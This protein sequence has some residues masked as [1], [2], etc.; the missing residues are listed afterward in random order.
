MPL[1]KPIVPPSRDALRILRQLAFAGTLGGVALA[2]DRRQRI[3]TAN[4]VRENERRLKASRYYHGAGAEAVKQLQ[5]YGLTGLGAGDIH[6]GDRTIN[7]KWTTPLQDRSLLPGELDRLYLKERNFKDR[8]T[9][10]AATATTATAPIKSSEK[11]HSKIRQVPVN[12]D[13]VMPNFLNSTRVNHGPRIRHVKS[14]VTSSNPLR[15]RILQKVLW[16]HEQTQQK[17]GSGVHGIQIVQNEGQGT[18]AHQIFSVQSQLPIESETILRGV[19]QKSNRNLH[20]VSALKVL[21]SEDPD[22]GSQQRCAVKIFDLLNQSSTDQDAALEAYA[23]ARAYLEGPPLPAEAELSY[24]L[25]K[26]IEVLDGQSYAAESLKIKKGLA[27]RESP[28]IISDLI[29]TSRMDEAFRMFSRFYVDERISKIS[30]YDIKVALRL[31]SS[32]VELN[33]TS[34]AKR[35]IERLALYGQ[36]PVRTIK[37]IFDC[38]E[39]ANA[40]AQIPELCQAIKIRNVADQGTMS[41]II[42]QACMQAGLYQEAE[43]AL[44]KGIRTG[45][46]DTQEMVPKFFEWAWESTNNFNRVQGLFDRIRMAYEGRKPSVKLFNAIIYISGL[47]NRSDTGNHYFNQ[48]IEQEKIQP[49]FLT[50]SALAVGNAIGNDPDTAKKNLL[51]ARDLKVFKSHTA[52]DEVMFLE[53]VEWVFFYYG[54]THHCPDLINY[55][56]DL[57]KELKYKPSG[58]SISIGLQSCIYAENLPKLVEW[59]EFLHYSGKVLG[60]RQAHAIIKALQHVRH[61]RTDVVLSFIKSL[62]TIGGGSLITDDMAKASYNSAK[63]NMEQGM[64]TSN[65]NVDPTFEG[66]MYEKAP[67]H[68]I[69]TRKRMQVAS[70][71]GRHE[72]VL[73]EFARAV[74][75]QVKVEFPI[76]SLAL[77]SRSACSSQ[78][79][80]LPTAVMIEETAARARVPLQQISN[81]QRYVFNA[82]DDG[83]GNHTVIQTILSDG[84]AL[85]EDSSPS[86]TAARKYHGHLSGAVSHAYGMGCPRT[87]IDLLVAHLNSEME[88]KTP[89]PMLGFMYL[90]RGYSLIGN[91]AGILWVGRELIKRDLDITPLRIDSFR[92]EIREAGRLSKG[93]HQALKE[94]LRDLEGLMQR[95]YRRVESWSKELIAVIEWYLSLPPAAK[96][97][98]YTGKIVQDSRDPDTQHNS[99]SGIDSMLD[100]SS[101][102]LSPST[103]SASSPSSTAT[104]QPNAPPGSRSP[105]TSLKHSKQPE[106]SPSET[107]RRVAALEEL[108]YAE[109]S[110]KGIR[111]PRSRT[112]KPR[113]WRDYSSRRH[114]RHSAP[115]RSKPLQPAASKLARQMTKSINLPVA[116]SAS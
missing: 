34:E 87:G 75:M 81:S 41:D 89:L 94:M 48:M 56:I 110:M 109:D 111:S 86:L 24:Q 54:K 104:R 9:R 59:L 78:D 49:N 19:A 102:Y 91:V 96:K 105:E 45:I 73:R 31:A 7:L 82:D 88:Q 51:T 95:Q 29:R 60:P 116:A 61:Q 28:K 93:D 16:K 66:H 18:D 114:D 58:F 47:A 33:H 4:R 83:I 106:Q 12:D 99:L 68:T 36:N 62:Q 69:D 35:V 2:E 21:E 32:L 30:P 65:M 22:R 92:S 85:F 6:E 101:S 13:F 40:Y 71:E 26:L 23:C 63:I 38:L 90:L 44:T 98:Y 52:E 74:K 11:L 8:K 80:S 20:T 50:Y 97:P 42:I 39:T 53:K 77:N 10:A 76:I 15:E 14:F 67:R 57:L 1:T 115:L 37:G 70:I 64:H 103:A 107:A 113:P 84:K 27:L 5:E 46:E 100:D 108:R 43:D 79:P 112:S 3:S 17:I 55:M 72:E 25:L